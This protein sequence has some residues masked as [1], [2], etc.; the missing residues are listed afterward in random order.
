MIALD[1]MDDGRLTPEMV[2]P[3]LSKGDPLVEQ[4]ALWV[5][6]HHGGW[7]QAM[8]GFFREWLAR[9]DMD[10][11]RREELARQLLAFAKDPTVQ[12][13]IGASLADPGTN[14]ET[15]LLLLEVIAAAAPGRL[16][17]AWA[18]PLAEA[19]DHPDE[20]VAGQAVT[21]LRASP[22]TSCPS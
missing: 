10:D 15:R 6:A 5:I 3:F 11:A 7:G 8:V 4:T 19:L 12:E 21:T 1:Q 9:R 2:T 13:L 22:W 16:P 18:E 20:R 17:D 14:V